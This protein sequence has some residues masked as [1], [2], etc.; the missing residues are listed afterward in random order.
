[1]N[2]HNA[3]I[4]VSGP[5]G[6]GKTTM[7]VNH[8]VDYLE[9]ATEP[10][11]VMLISTD[12]ANGSRLGDLVYDKIK[13]K[14]HTAHTPATQTILWNGHRITYSSHVKKGESPDVVGLDEYLYIEESEL[15]QLNIMKPKMLIRTCRTNFPPISVKS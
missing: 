11:R 13:F 1:M 10:Q 5:A 12:Y 4:T 7:M 8:I 3:P 9:H 14:G 2:T 15:E 6:A